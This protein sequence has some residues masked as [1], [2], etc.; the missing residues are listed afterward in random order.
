MSRELLRELARINALSKEDFIKQ[1]ISLNSF[2]EGCYMGCTK[3]NEP[4][5]RAMRRLTHKML[6][7]MWEC[8]ME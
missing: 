4:T 5:Y 7:Q 6:V 2:A 1:E 8:Y 3:M